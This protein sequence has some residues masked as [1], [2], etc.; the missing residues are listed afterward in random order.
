MKKGIE[1]ADK[2]WNPITGCLNIE[3]GNCSVGK[4]CWAYGMSLRLRG[5]CGYDAANPFKPTFH[6]DKLEDPLK[7][8]K[9]TVY[10]TCFMGDIAFAEKEWLE[11][12]LG[13]IRKCPQHRFIFLTKAP[14]KLMMNN[15]KFPDNCIVGVTVN[16]EKDVWRISELVHHINAKYKWLSVEPMY[17]RLNISIDGIDWLVIGAQSNPVKQPD[18]RWVLELMRKANHRNIPIFLK[19]NLTIIE[20]TMELPEVLKVNT[21]E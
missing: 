14:N 6:E 16:N 20:L 1:Y 12:V 10:D 13:V 2:S 21:N 7:R 18:I 15:L 5:R 19:P 3:K 4:R 9:P 8:K 11:K 17:E